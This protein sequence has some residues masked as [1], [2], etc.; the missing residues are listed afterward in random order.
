M[1]AMFNGD[2]DTPPVQLERYLGDAWNLSVSIVNTGHIGYSPEQYYYS[3]LEYGERV[4]PHFVV[5][6]VCPNDFGEGSAVLRGEGDW[7]KEAAYWL[8]KVKQWCRAH[9]AVCLI[10][11][12]PVFGQVDLFRQEE[13]YPC[14]IAGMLH[15]HPTLYCFP[16]DQFIDES[17]RLAGQAVREGKERGQSRLYNREINDDHF[18]PRGAELW[19]KIVGGRL[20]R[21]FNAN[22]PDSTRPAGKPEAP[23]RLRQHCPSPFDDPVPLEGRAG[24]DLVQLNVIMPEDPLVSSQFRVAQLAANKVPEASR[25]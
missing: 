4:R 3:L 2:G 8:E 15:V 6:S 17:L 24:I 20:I 16:L 21:F 25:G 22:P 5:V 1:Q 13:F 18:S 12:V 9:L 23:A 14:Q 10:V 11:P 7:M 19:A